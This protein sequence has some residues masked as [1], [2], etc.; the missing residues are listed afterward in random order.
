M[1]F[2]QFQKNLMELLLIIMEFEK[3]IK[4]E[5]SQVF[6]NINNL[7]NTKELNL[8]NHIKQIIQD[9]LKRSLDLT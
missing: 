1:E 5:L 8:E 7:P 2:Q 3:E 6:L 9:K 4:Q